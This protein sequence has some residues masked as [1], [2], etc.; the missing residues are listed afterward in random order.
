MVQK[1]PT[2]AYLVDIKRYLR[3]NFKINK[4]NTKYWLIPMELSSE[5]S[6][7]NKPQQE[8]DDKE[9]PKHF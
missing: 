5:V 4:E 2:Q 3:L 8:K 7:K 6:K 9:M 1:Q